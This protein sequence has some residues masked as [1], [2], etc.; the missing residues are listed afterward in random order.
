MLSRQAITSQ[1][2][3]ELQMWMLEHL[4]DSLSVEAMAER[5]DMSPRHFARVS[6]RETGMTPGHFVDRMRVEAA[7][8]MIDRH[9]VAHDARHPAVHA[10]CSGAG[11][12]WR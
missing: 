10:H 2:L 9:H 3:R 8:Q 1:P 4:R 7:Q 11:D 5:I 6:Q 12:G